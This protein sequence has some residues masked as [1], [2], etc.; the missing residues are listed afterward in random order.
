[1]LADCEHGLALGCPVTVTSQRMSVTLQLQAAE[2]KLLTSA[3]RGVGL[4]CL[5]PQLAYHCHARQSLATEGNY[6]AASL[7]T[8]LCMC[9]VGLVAHSSAAQ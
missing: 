2:R 8:G 1:M 7:R 4:R 3:L 9:L 5:P 6:G